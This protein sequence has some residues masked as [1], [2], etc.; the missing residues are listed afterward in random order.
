MKVPTKAKVRMVPI[1]RKKL[2][3]SSDQ[4]VRTGTRRRAAADLMQLVSGC[5]D[6][7]WKEEVEKKLIVEFDEAQDRFGT[8]EL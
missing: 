5:Q 2:P 3:C 6:D 4:Y 8:D 7:G 1:F